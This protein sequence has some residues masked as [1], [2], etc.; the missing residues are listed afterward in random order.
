ML[1]LEH[2]TFGYKNQLLKDALNLKVDLPQVVAVLGNNGTGKSTFFNALRQ[3]I[4]YEGK[5]LVN[6]KDLSSFVLTPFVFLGQAYTFT[7]DIEVDSFLKINL[8]AGT[9]REV[10][11]FLYSSLEIG[12]LKK[13]SI[14]E[15]SQ[16]QLQ[17]CLIMQTLLQD[18][19]F[20][21]LDEPESF[22]DLYFRGVL[23]KTL[24]EFTNLYG[25]TVLVT[26]HDLNLVQESCSTFL[27]FS[28]DSPKLLDVSRESLLEQR[29]I[30]E[31][32]SS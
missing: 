3:K 7:L 13:K 14:T 24:K 11:N 25:K 18:S 2:F 8:G 32:R 28:H 29:L 16:G 12:E 19:S 10:Y 20:Y 4:N 15:I 22:L 26:T 5:V 21:L 27:N 31:K 30:L 1:S 6:H 9:N 17:R 23:A